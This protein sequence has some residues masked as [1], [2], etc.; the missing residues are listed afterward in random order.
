[1]ATSSDM[2]TNVGLCLYTVM[3]P[4]FNPNLQIDQDS[5]QGG[6]NMEFPLPPKNL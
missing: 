3:Y 2:S 4:S 6:G 1:M 5:I